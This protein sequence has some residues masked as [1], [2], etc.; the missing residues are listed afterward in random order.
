MKIVERKLVRLSSGEITQGHLHGVSIHPTGALLACKEAYDAIINYGLR[1]YF[2]KTALV[3]PV[4]FEPAIDYLW[5][6]HVE[7]I[8]KFAYKTM[9]KEFFPDGNEWSEDYAGRNRLLTQNSENV[10]ALVFG[11]VVEDRHGNVTALPLRLSQTQQED[12]Q[13]RNSPDRLYFSGGRGFWRRRGGPG[14][15]RLGL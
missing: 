13:P 6:T 15:A 11:N 7:H 10:A 1:T 4:L 12:L 3:R 5:F 14:F 8:E 9:D 2:F